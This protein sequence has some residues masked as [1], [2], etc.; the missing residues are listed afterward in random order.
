MSE[1]ILDRT[2]EPVQRPAT[3]PPPPATVGRRRRVRTAWLRHL[4][5]IVFG[6]FMLYPLLWMTVSAF[7]PS[8]LVLSDPSLI[9]SEL[10]LDNFRQGW[11]SANQPFWVFFGNS[12]V[13]AVSSIVGNLFSCSLTAYALARLEFRARKLYFAIVLVSVMLPMHVV[14]IPQY[15]VFSQLDLV[16]TFVPLILPKFLATDAFFIFLM[17]QFIRSIPR[18]L[19]QAAWLDGAGPFKTFWY[20]VLPL[21][22]PALV[23]TAIFTFI[24]TWN[25]FFGQLIYLTESSVFTVPV[26]LNSLVD[27]QSQS[28]IGMLLAMS[29]LTLLPILA[30]FVFAQKYLIQGISTTGLK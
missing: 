9:P 10:T 26:A 29:V 13:V 22:R 25:D 6:L 2:L 8:N 7:K 28:G 12:L 1:Q 17:V 20:V 30:F 14:V 11:T 16:N 15:I 5:L 4:G 19:D 18:D 23:T 21:M 24:W 3:A 27:S